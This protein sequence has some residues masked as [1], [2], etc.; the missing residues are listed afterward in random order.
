MMDSKMIKQMANGPY[1]LGI[2]VTSKYITSLKVMGKSLSARLPGFMVADGNYHEV[3]RMS[4]RRLVNLSTRG[5][6]NG[7]RMVSQLGC[8]YSEARLWASLSQQK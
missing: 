1:S 7:P 3:T 6:H 2:L 4:L 8:M 5:I